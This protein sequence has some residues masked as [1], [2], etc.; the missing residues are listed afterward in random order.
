M[1][2]LTKLAFA[3]SLGLVSTLAAAQT[4]LNVWEDIQKSKGITQA[5]ADF[6]KQFDVKVNIQEMPFTQQIEKIRL[7]GPAGIGPDVLVIPHDQ[8]G[9]AVVQN[10]ITPIES[11][12]QNADKYIDSAI[13]AFTAQGK[14]YGVP[15]VV[16]TIVMFYNKDKIAKP[17]ESL[18]DYYEYSKKE[19]KDGNFG[20]LAKFDSIYYAYGAL[21]PMGAYV[22]KRDADGN[23]DA[24]DVGLANEGAVKG[25]EY[26]KKFYADGLFP[27]GI[28][29]DNGINAIDSLFTEGT[30]AAVINGPWAVEPYQKA[31][32]NFGVAPLPKLPNGKDM[33]SFMGVKGYVISNWAKN[34]E[35]A[36]KFLNFI[37]QP[38]YAAIRFKET[39]EIPP[40]K[41]VMADSIIKDNPVA[42]AI[43]TQASRATPMPSIPEMS[44]VWGPIDAALQLSVTGKQD[45]KAALTGAT[46]HIHNQIEA[47]RSGM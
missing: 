32:V 10:L 28:V 1:I 44:E 27:T 13:S 21:S 6:E 46:E 39:M 47:F 34:H 9:A 29:G 33:S 19:T 24:T 5:V 14:I 23:F 18:E 36:E 41:E 4:E 11:M 30:A 17:F 16:E 7:D 26:L 3:V 38:K 15:K 45:V 40:V 25:V 12:D 42:E 8:L 35:L 31:G 37:N 22:F 2:K 20:L 43:A